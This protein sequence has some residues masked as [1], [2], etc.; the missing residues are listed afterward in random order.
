MAQ[1]AK[2]DALQ[3]SKI[4]C[5]LWMSTILPLA[6]WSAVDLP[7]GLPSILRPV[8]VKAMWLMGLCWRGE[9]LKRDTARVGDFPLK[10][11]QWC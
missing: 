8:H 10:D 9:L 1:T 2:H 7:V 4:V 6:A 5:Y 3:H 11:L